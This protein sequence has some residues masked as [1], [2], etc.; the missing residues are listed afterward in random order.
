VAHQILNRDLTIGRHGF[1][2][3]FAGLARGDAHVG[4]F[5]EV[6]AQGIVNQDLALLIKHKGSHRGHRLGHRCNIENR[7]RRHRDSA[8]LVAPAIG[9]QR[10]QFAAP[11]DRDH[12]AGYAAR[13]DIGFEHRADPGQ[14]FAREA[15]LFRL[16][17]R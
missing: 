5:G 10:Y 15:D 2:G 4:K 6:F 13:L 16:A 12:R 3:G 17:A 7:V 1:G 14:P 9:I 8:R 11:C